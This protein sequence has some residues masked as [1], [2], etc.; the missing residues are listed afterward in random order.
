MR[1]AKEVKNKKT[2]GRVKSTLKLW[3][4]EMKKKN[5]FIALLSLTLMVVALASTAVSAKEA[6]TIDELVAMYDDSKCAKCHE[7]IY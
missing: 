2:R 3:R 5:R 1:L 4:E 7:D 6:N